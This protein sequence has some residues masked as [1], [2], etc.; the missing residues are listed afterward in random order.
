M[1]RTVRQKLLPFY[2]SSAPDLHCS[3]RAGGCVAHASHGLRLFAQACKKRN[4]S[5][6]IL[7]V[8]IRA[9]YYRVI[10]QFA[11]SPESQEWTEERLARLFQFFNL[12]AADYHQLR[13]GLAAGGECKSSGVPAQ[14]E[15]LASEMLSSTWF[16]TSS[17][18][19]LH[20]SLAG[21][22][23]GDGLADLIFGYVFKRI[24]QRVTH[25]LEERFGDFQ[26][27]QPRPLDLTL[28]E[29]PDL[30]VLKVVEVVWADDLAIGVQ[31]SDGGSLVDD[32]KFLASTV[33]E[34]CINHAMV[35]QTWRWGRRNCCWLSV[36][37][38]GGSSKQISSTMR[39]QLSQYQ[40]SMKVSLRYDWPQFT[41]IWEQGSTWVP[42]WC[43]NFEPDWG[44][45]QQY[46]GSTAKSSSRTRWYL[47]RSESFFSRALCW[48]YWSTMPV[49]GW[50]STR[51]S[52]N[53]SRRS[54]IR[55]IEDFW[56]RRHQKRNWDSGARKKSF[57]S[58]DYLM[59]R[60]SFWNRGWDTRSHCTSQDLLHFGVWSWLNVI[61]CLDFK[62][63]TIG[64]WTVYEVM[65][66]T[67]G[68]KLGDLTFI[69][70]CRRRTRA[71][72][73]GLGRQSSWRDFRDAYVQSG[74][75]GTL[76]TTG[77]RWHLVWKLNCHVYKATRSRT[78][79]A[80]TLAYV[81]RSSS[82]VVQLGRFMLS[83]PME[84]SQSAEKW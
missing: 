63:H 39:I 20:E 52:S 34:E 41:S 8:D 40:L 49:L 6:G 47:C 10:R 44:R 27:P 25:K 45:R 81:A 19:S 30:P 12:E 68:V 48:A 15:H 24:M 37:K 65:D 80:L 83:G 54:S 74:R 60:R 18:D 75:I 26:F 72:N 42:R 14:L 58:L 61:G 2:T 77:W 35:P 69:Y 46:T 67:R 4:L 29:I 70:G 43:Q 28:K 16:V 9:A 78:C 7:F 55:C 1:R 79:R 11:A 53:T 23:P 66:R 17:R 73:L 5:S 57:P 62:M 56:G 59:L 64:C 32:I 38:E 33:I 50:P 22:R 31:N 51:A 21:S 36:V 71:S 82:S 13:A 84:G 76:T 3:V